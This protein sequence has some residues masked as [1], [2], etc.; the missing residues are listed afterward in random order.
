MSHIL[1]ISKK[2]DEMA[3]KIESLE[4][5]VKDLKEEAKEPV[6]GQWEDISKDMEKLVLQKVHNEIDEYRERE[7]RKANIIVHNMAEPEGVSPQDRRAADEVKF[8][9]V[10]EELKVNNPA[11]K[12]IVRLGQ[13]QAGGKP[14]LTKVVMVEVEK[15]RELLQAAKNLRKSEDEALKKIYITPDLSKQA[16]EE[17]KKLKAEL[18]RRKEDGE[19]NLVIKRGKIVTREDRE[20]GA[21]EEA[22]EDIAGPNQGVRRDTNS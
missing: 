6:T 5:A 7:I 9:K 13:K 11:I 4:V 19:P 12:S 2:Q 8:R 14:R 16:R 15:K 10:A 21:G 18:D 3:Q 20:T 17:G 1:R 22:I